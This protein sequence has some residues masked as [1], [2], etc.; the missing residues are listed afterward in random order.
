MPASSP[1]QTTADLRGKR[2]AFTKASS[3]H[4]LVIK[5]LAHAGMKL[6]DVQPIYLSP[7]DAASAFARNAVDAWNPYPGAG[8]AGPEGAGVDLGRQPG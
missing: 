5:A 4:P 6:T 2:I 3:S 7:S 8:P 1:L